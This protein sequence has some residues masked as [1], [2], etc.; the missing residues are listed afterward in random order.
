MLRMQENNFF[1]F[2]SF[3]LLAVTLS[4][5]L[6]ILIF[7]KSFLLKFYILQAQHLYEKREGSGCGS[8]PQFMDPDPGGPKTC[9]SCGSE[10]PTLGSYLPIPPVQVLE[11]ADSGDEKAI[12]AMGLLNTMETILAVMEEKPEVRRRGGTLLSSQ[13]WAVFGSGIRIRI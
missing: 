1:M 3:N 12:T 13:C 7:C 6:K 10:S 9:G 5:L 11:T 2:V 8:I 4:S